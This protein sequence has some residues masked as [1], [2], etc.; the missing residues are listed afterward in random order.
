MIVGAFGQGMDTVVNGVDV[1]YFVC[2]TTPCGWGQ[3][4]YLADENCQR[5]WSV[6]GQIS[7]LK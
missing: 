6:I 1:R 7:V 3:V 2:P 5:V 4:G